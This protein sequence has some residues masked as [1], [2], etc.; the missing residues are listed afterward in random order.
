MHK[1]RIVLAVTAAVVIALLFMGIGYAVFTGDART[2]NPD[3]KETLAYMS[4]TPTDFNAIFNDTYGVGTSIFDTYVYAGPNTAY[5]FDEGMTVVDVA[6]DQQ[7]TYKAVELG[8]KNLTVL[9]NTNGDI[10]ALRVDINATGTVGNASFVY[11][12]KLVVDQ[13]TKYIVFDGD[14]TG[15]T[16]INAAIND[17]TSGTIALTVYVGYIPNVQVPANYIGP[18][19]N[20]VNYVSAVG[21]TYDANVTY[22]TESQGNYSA[23]NPQPADQAAINEGGYYL[24]SLPYIQTTNAPI[25]LST[26]SFG[27]EV[28]DASA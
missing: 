26:T 24:A 3:D 5:A 11:I 12:F 10:T 4:V 1:N 17:E 13:T 14:T 7:T 6:V 18:A 20:D 19:T 21:T 8:A 2:Y 27:I 22:Y 15:Y 23:A 16:T 9:N 28:T 25:D